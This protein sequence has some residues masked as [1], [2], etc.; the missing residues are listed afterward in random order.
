MSSDYNNVSLTIQQSRDLM[1][2]ETTETIQQYFN[3]NL[4]EYSDLSYAVYLDDIMTFS[5]QSQGP[6]TTCLDGT[7]KPLGSWCLC[8][9]GKM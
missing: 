4:C 8:Q 1:T 9:R 6:P 2:L 7:Q 3:D 5:K